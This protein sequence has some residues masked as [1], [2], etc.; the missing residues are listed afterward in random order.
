MSWHVMICHH[1]VG[2]KSTK[3]CCICGNFGLEIQIIKFAKFLARPRNIW[4]FPMLARAPVGEADERVLLRHLR[5]NRVRAAPHPFQTESQ[6]KIR[7]EIFRPDTSDRFF[8]EE[9]KILLR[10]TR[11]KS[12]VESAP[13]SKSVPIP[14]PKWNLLPRT[15]NC[16]TCFR[17]S[18]D[19]RQSKMDSA[20]REELLLERNFT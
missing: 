7:P 4:A 9:E 5:G 2:Q 14:N 19:S 12:R 16:A 18:L 17:N 3:H 1:N 8:L 11:S 20:F 13:V 6:P 10:T 15:K